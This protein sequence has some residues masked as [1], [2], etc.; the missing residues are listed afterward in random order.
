VQGLTQCDPPQV[1]LPKI[2]DLLVETANYKP[3]LLRLIAVAFLELHWKADG[4][5]NEYLSPGLLQIS[6]YLE[7]NIEHGKLRRVDSTILTTALMM[8]T[9]LHPGI[10]RLINRGHRPYQRSPEDDRAYTRFWLD[11]LSPGLPVVQASS[12]D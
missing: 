9:L 5:G 12:P 7:T 1:V 3:E 8:T 2:L 11:L 6:E 10:S 4:F